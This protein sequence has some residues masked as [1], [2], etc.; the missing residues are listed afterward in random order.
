[1]SP[2]WYSETVKIVTSTR[3]A[4]L[5]VMVA[6]SLA[7]ACG[8][9]THLTGTSLGNERAPDFQLR[10]SSGQGYSLDQFRGKVVVLTFLYTRCPDYCPLTAEL[11]RH[12]D[13]AAGHPANVVYL[14]VSVDP[15]GDTPENIA[16]F[17]QQHHLDELGN[18]WHYLTG[19]PAVLAGVWRSYYIGAS[20]AATPQQVDHTSAIYFI[21]RQGNRRVVSEL[22]VAA[23]DLARNELLLAKH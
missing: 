5:A 16:T 13:E 14:A 6:L 9:S 10:D 23:E 18:R 8:P 20:A 11:L 21:D 1:V 17:N 19:D 22:D 3:G 7:I 12:A 4:V 2:A 15:T